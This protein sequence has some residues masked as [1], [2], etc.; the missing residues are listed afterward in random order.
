MLI[1]F[2]MLLPFGCSDSEPPPTPETEPVAEEEAEPPPPKKRPRS[3]SQSADTGLDFD[4]LIKEIR[5]NPTK[6][7]P[8]ENITV[9]VEFNQSSGYVDVDYE[10]EVNG[11]RL[12]SE[13]TEELA[14]RRFNKGDTVQ[15]FL[16]IRIGEDT[17]QR[18]GALLIVGNTPP[19]ILTNPN[20]LSKLD[21]FRIRGE[22]PDGGAVTYYVKG[23]P[24]GLSIGETTGVVRYTPSKTAE[25][26][27]FP[28][29]FIVRDADQAESEWRL[30]V[31]VSAGSDSET[32]KAERAKRKADWEAEQAAKKAKR[33]AEAASNTDD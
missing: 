19:R 25:G 4:D 32:A 12:L 14:H 2:F 26:G 22:D 1:A 28:L 20:S 16:S 30:T 33:E 3:G 18:E 21:G 7:V 27:E 17:L 8:H 6:P 23:G 10:W 9:S 15:A 24:P 29:T 13:R 31:N 11:R 5:Y